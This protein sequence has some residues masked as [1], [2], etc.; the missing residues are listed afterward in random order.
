MKLVLLITFLF[1]YL[2]A[3]EV[4]ISTEGGAKNVFFNLENYSETTVDSE[5]WQLAFKSGAIAG[6]IRANNNTK[7]YVALNLSIDD[8][9]SPI[10]SSALTNTAEFEELHNDVTDWKMGAFNSGG[11]PESDYNYGWGEY[12]QGDG[13]YGTKLFVLEITD[14][15]KKEYRQFVINSVYS[16][17]YYI[18]WCDLDGSNVQTQEINKS[19]FSDKMFVYLDLF[20]NELLN[21]E[22]NKHL[23][24]LVFTDYIDFIQMGNA[25]MYYKVAGVLQNEMTWVSELEG[26]VT[27]KPEY[28]TF[29]PQINTIGYDWKTYTNEYVIEDKTYF[30]Q[31]F[32][33]D[34]EFNPVPVG[35]MYRIRFSNYEGGADKASTFNVVTATSSVDENGNSRFGIYPNVISQGES[36]NI[37]WN[38]GVNVITNDVKV[39]NSNGEVVYQKALPSSNS[40]SNMQINSN[41]SAGL[42]F[43]VFTSGQDIFT[44]KLM[45]K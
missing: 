26:D 20:E 42:Y 11:S 4:R 19:S 7:V 22:P 16:N 41:L 1:T 44:Q 33:Y 24:D 23:W 25:S 30:L 40:L 35:E 8:F 32:E 38:E 29:S 15:G 27:T 3:E 18:E 17:T 9:Q 6:T 28:S 39:I 12:S 2:S 36:F 34:V 31:K 5:N 14:A 37:L 10:E 21:F 45:V 43:V 13:I